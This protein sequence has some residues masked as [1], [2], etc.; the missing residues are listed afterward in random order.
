MHLALSAAESDYA[1]AGRAHSFG[2]TVAGAAAGILLRKLVES[3]GRF[4]DLT[5][6]IVDE[7]H[8]YELLP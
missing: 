3:G 5:H 6:I 7:V 2:D 1:R 8:R 4:E